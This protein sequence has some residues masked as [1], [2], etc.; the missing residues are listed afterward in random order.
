MNFGGMSAKV[1]QLLQPLKIAHTSMASEYIRL[2]ERLPDGYSLDRVLYNIDRSYDYW[3][4]AFEI[5]KEFFEEQR[6]KPFLAM[7]LVVSN[8]DSEDLHCSFDLT[9][10][11]DGCEYPEYPGY[12]KIDESIAPVEPLKTAAAF[13][14]ECVERL[15][16]IGFLV[17]PLFYVDGLAGLYPVETIDGALIVEI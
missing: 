11:Y 13:Y 2:G 9:P 12:S 5:G 8:S 1:H 10:F 7:G 16:E 4:T 14:N 15:F 6:W 3:M 17:F